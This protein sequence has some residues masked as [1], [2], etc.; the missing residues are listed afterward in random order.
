M[1]GLIHYVDSQPATVPLMRVAAK[2]T[3]VD[4]SA[5]VQVTQEYRN[6]SS[7]TLDCSY[8]FPVPAR[9]AVCAFAVLKADGSRIR[10]V[11]QEK[12]EARA[13]YDEA[14][15]QGRLASL[16]EQDSPDSQSRQ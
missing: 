7:E 14:V 13:T 3:I 9:G 8:Q 5:R 1:H 4:L 2:A 12:D 10:G 11:V 16:M 15:E 6:D